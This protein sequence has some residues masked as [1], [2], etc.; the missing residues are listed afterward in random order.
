MDSSQLSG[1]KRVKHGWMRVGNDCVV[2][3][4]GCRNGRKGI[5]GDVRNFCKGLPSRRRKRRQ[6]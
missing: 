4:K 3:S 1:P 5:G 2:T 6:L